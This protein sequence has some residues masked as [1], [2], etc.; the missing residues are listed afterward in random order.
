MAYETRI[1]EGWIRREILYGVG[2]GE[3]ACVAEGRGVGYSSSDSAEAMSQEGLTRKDL[4]GCRG[5]S[6]L[7]ID[8]TEVQ[9]VQRKKTR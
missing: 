1:G 3:E 6:V 8:S 7:V 2:L 4:N 9:R 5:E